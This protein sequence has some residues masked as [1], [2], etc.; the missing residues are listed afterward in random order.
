MICT[1]CKNDV[2]ENKF[3]F[4][5]KAKGIRHKICPDCQNKYKN[6]YY[7]L[8]KEEYKPRL[9]KQREKLGKFYNEYKSQFT[10]LICKEAEVVCLD[11]H[12]LDG[13]DKKY[14]PSRLR[15]VSIKKMEEEFAKCVILCSNCHRKVHAGIIN[16]NGK[17][18]KQKE[19]S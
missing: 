1:K 17:D 7:S 4:K 8:H 5:N 10:C 2:E 18:N 11:F 9:Q 15:Q 14:N 6:K 3:Y 19:M 12:H 16:L 13:K